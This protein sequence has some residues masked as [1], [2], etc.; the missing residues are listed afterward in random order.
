MKKHSKIHPARIVALDGIRGLAIVL[1]FLTHARI[2]PFFNVLPS[3]GKWIFALFSQNGEVGVAILFLL[4]GYLM[5]TLYPTVPSVLQFWQKRYTRIFP[6]FI[7]MATLLSVVRFFWLWIPNWVIIGLFIAILWIGSQLWK[8]VR[9]HPHRRKLGIQIFI[10]F[11]LLQ[12]VSS[13]G[14]IILQSKV[15]SAVYYLVW[16]KWIVQVI[17]WW[18][19]TTMVLPFGKYVSQLDGVYWSVCLEVLFYLLYPIVFLPIFTRVVSK[20]SK[21]LNMTALLASAGFFF[22]LSLIGKTVFGLYL[23]QLQMGIFFVMGMVMS[24]LEQSAFV[25][26]AVRKVQL[27][28]EKLL[29]V[30]LLCGTIGAPIFWRT[31]TIPSEVQ[32][33]VWAI[34]LSLVFLLTQHLSTSWKRW[35]SSKLFVLLG[36]YSYAIYLTHT[37]VLE[38]LTRSGNPA[39][40]IGSAWLLI[41][42]VGLVMV[43]SFFVHRTLERPYFTDRL[44]TPKKFSSPPTL[45]LLKV[46]SWSNQMQFASIVVVVVFA[47]FFLIWYAN[48]APVSL[49]AHINNYQSQTP[50]QQLITV[51]QP[52][53]IPFTAQHN[54]LGMLFVH[55]KPLTSQEAKV[56]GA[57]T[58]GDNTLAALHVEI[59]KEAGEVIASADYPLYQIYESR[60][61]PLGLPVQ[62][63]SEDQRYVLKL[64]STD[65]QAHSYVGLMNE[66]VALRSVYFVDKQQLLSRPSALLAHLLHLC[67]QPF[68]EKQAI[69]E[70]LLMAPFLGILLFLTMKPWRGINRLF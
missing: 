21:W 50:R 27:I 60:F 35:L 34:P 43:F 13:I 54:G 59:K 7:A 32:L 23:L 48:R 62:T 47:T 10:V 69:L 26:V 30:L 36:Q 22:G 55:I 8:R 39:T 63:N 52:V 11:L 5:K 68:M 31:V 15:P 20:K 29:S 3:W 1:V 70:V 4:S 51:E 6:A 25:K 18:I 41:V 58:F 66:G 45:S 56:L 42:S 9:I 67:K 49:R 33:I 40:M 28:P 2:D 24:H 46:P 44:S 14:Y 37:V 12:V 57:N 61:F 53:E 38:M 64:S 17:G 65:A 19:N 16:P